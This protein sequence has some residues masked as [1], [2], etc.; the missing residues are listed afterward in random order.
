MKQTWV[1]LS[2]GG[3]FQGISFGEK[4]MKAEICLGQVLGAASRLC[5]CFCWFAV[6]RALLKCVL[7]WLNSFSTLPSFDIP[8]QSCLHSGQACYTSGEKL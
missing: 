2:G 6:L 3:V 7:L 5:F 8:G 1:Q 4:E